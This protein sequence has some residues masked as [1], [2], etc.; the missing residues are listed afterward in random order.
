M[1]SSLHMAII[2]N[3]RLTIKNEIS[4]LSRLSDRESYRGFG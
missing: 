2:D 3:E 1:I 4:I